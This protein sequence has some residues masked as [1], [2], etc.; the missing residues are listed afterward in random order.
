MSTDA[1]QNYIILYSI[2]I[3]WHCSSFMFNFINGLQVS[4]CLFCIAPIV[5]T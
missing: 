1:K 3:I 2:R 4:C 5:L